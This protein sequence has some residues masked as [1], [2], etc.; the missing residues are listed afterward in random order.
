[1]TSR[2]NPFEY[3]GANDLPP[4][5]ILDYYV[6]DFNYSRFIQ[7]NRNV[8]LV[9]ERGCGKSMTLLYNSWAIQ[10]R[11]A[12][13]DGHAPSLDLIGIYVPCNTPLTHKGE[14]QLC[15]RF[16]AQVISEHHLVLSIAFRIAETLARIPN[17]L[18]GADVDR[19]RDKIEFVFAKEMPSGA[20]LF[21]GL[22]E[23][24]ERESLET[25]RRIN[26]PKTAEVA[27]ND[28]Y[29]F[30]S[31]VAPLLGCA[32]LMPALARSHFML[33]ID[34]AHDLNEHQ[35]RSLNSWIAYRD[36]SLF[37]FKVALASIG[38]ASL[39]TSSG[40]SILE[41]HD[42]T[43]LNMVQPFHNEA[44]DFGRFAGQM[45]ARRLDK[46]G[47]EATPDTFFPVSP[48]LL[49]DL[50][51]SEETVRAEAIAKYGDD[52][53]K[54]SDHVYKYKRAH[55]FR[56]RS[57]KANRP[58]YSGFDT[59]V[60]LSTGVIRNLLQPCYWMYDKMLSLSGQAEGVQGPIRGIPPSIQT[61]IILDRSRSLWDW[62]RDELGQSIEGCSSE[63]AGRCHQLLDQLAT[64]FRERLLH[65][66]SEPRAVSFTISGR[67]DDLMS[68]LNH[69]FRILRE[70]QLLYIRSGSAKDKGRREWYY[71]PN[72]MLWPERGLDPHGQHARVSLSAAE[73]WAAASEN[74]PIAVRD[75]A[76]ELKGL[77][78]E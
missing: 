48:Q 30:S 44:S 70:A 63:D 54:V 58:E 14:Y 39:R 19:L 72:R 42:Y 6:E 49:A 17:A 9:G 2:K 1:M 27:Y 62:L 73:L 20:S 18:D 50:K 34:D 13:L 23:F 4:D 15:D 64:H 55:Y 26:D 21:D 10:Q 67:T 52:P 66:K 11:K 31:L 68:K 41:G 71:I 28:T 74:R 59:L 78:D 12:E 77:F 69:L 25:Q 7:S 16:Q 53:R 61:E 29:T 47:I 32:R 51:K 45:I 38:K 57:T 75:E 24:V 46:C 37:S 40:G 65:H 5:M 22:M 35:L 76:A 36:H 43:R 3:L 33:L 56:S 60:F 8:L